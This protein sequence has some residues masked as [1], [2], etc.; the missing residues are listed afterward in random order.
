MSQTSPPTITGSPTVPQRADRATFSAR[1]DAFVTWM[2]AA[3]T[4]FGAVATNVYGNAVDAYNN[5]VAGAASAAAAST[6]EGN[7][8]ASASAAATSAGALMWVSGT[9]YALGAAAWSPANR[10]VYRKIT[11][12]S[13]S[14][15]DPSLDAT[16]WANVGLAGLSVITVSATTQTAVSGAHYVLTNV[17]ATT[18]TL[19]A[20][21]ASGDTVAITPDNALTTNV[22]ARNGQSIMG[23]GED[24][25][26][27][28][29]T[30]TVTLRF[31]NN[32]WRLI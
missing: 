24:M 10:L 4:E 8:S 23:L 22:I 13:V 1:V 5:A 21:P 26:L 30:A 11:A 2:A 32:S 17:A 14:T 16:N 7:A 19:P 31:L 29:A 3:V 20:S 28:N 12:S 25:T 9:T 18:L 27:D 15:T 6:S